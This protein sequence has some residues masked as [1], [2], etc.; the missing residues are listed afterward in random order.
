MAAISLLSKSLPYIIRSY[1]GKFQKAFGFGGKH[2]KNSYY[3][4]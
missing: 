3:F 1:I 4:S 2:E